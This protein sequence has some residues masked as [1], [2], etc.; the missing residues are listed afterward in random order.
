MGE[1]EPY[2]CIL[3]PHSVTTCDEKPPL[4]SE[5]HCKT[6]QR[7]KKKMKKFGVTTVLN[8]LDDLVASSFLHL[9]PLSSYTHRSPRNTLQ[10]LSLSPVSKV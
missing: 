10:T 3:L 9:L 6:G 7:E 8:G 1:M 5:R 4:I 2:Q